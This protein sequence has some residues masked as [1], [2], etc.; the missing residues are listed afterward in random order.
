MF[1]VGILVRML[2]LLIHGFV[3]NVRGDRNSKV[4]TGDRD[5]KDMMGDR[6]FKDF[7]GN[8]ESNITE[9]EFLSL[10]LHFETQYTILVIII[11]GHR[12]Q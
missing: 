7:T 2:L 12:L 1:Y 11:R 3:K 6:D 4:N 9:Y 5:S 10:L 8:K